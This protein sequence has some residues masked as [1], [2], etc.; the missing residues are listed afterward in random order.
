[1]SL[2]D[3]H[4]SGHLGLQ[5]QQTLGPET[6]LRSML[7]HVTI[8]PH[9]KW[10]QWAMWTAHIPVFT[11]RNTPIVGPSWNQHLPDTLP[12]VCYLRKY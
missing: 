10:R 1:M 2:Y 11:Y 9:K 5:S 3:T 12:G 6:R 7:W 4:V 8:C